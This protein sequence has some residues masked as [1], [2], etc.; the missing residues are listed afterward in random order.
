MTKDVERNTVSIRNV[1]PRAGK[2]GL[3][4]PLIGAT[5]RRGDIVEVSAEHAAI[6]LRQ[7]DVWQSADDAQD[8]AARPSDNAKKAAWVAHAEHLGVDGASDMT[9]PELMEATA[10]AIIENLDASPVPTDESGLPIL[11][12]TTD[13]TNTTTPDGE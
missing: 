8:P 2:A 10:P 1:S 3:D 12:E 5:V 13:D 4:V 9:K 6:L 7:V 11:Q